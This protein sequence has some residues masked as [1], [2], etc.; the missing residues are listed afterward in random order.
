MTDR[1]APAASR[2]PLRFRADGRFRLMIFS[3]IQEY[4]PFDERVSAFLR[5]AL[6]REQPDLV[7]FGGDNCSGPDIHSREAFISFLDSLLAPVEERG[8][9]WAHLFGNHDHDLFL[10]DD[11]EERL[12]ESHLGCLTG[13]VPG[14]HG[15]TNFVLP[16][17]SRSG[18]KPVFAVWG[19][20]T[21][22]RAAELDSLLPEGC[23]MEPLSYLPRRATPHG[24]WDTLR[25]DQ[26][27]WYW[28]RS[29]ALEAE[30]GHRVPGLMCL[31]IAPEEFQLAADHPD[32]FP[33]S[34]CLSERLGP[35]VLNSG[36][37]SALVQRGDIRCI[38]CGHTHQNDGETELCGIRLCY[39]AS[40]GTRCY[41]D[42]ATRGCRVF[43][44][45]EDE[46]EKPVTR[47]VHR[48]EFGL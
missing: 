9:P 35:A 6:D 4:D 42:E 46:P 36:L 32:I 15:T 33:A 19:L 7:L 22:N 18:E 16:I 48:S 5:A 13:T 31:H 27:M 44:I 12:Y 38:A 45:F 34:G 2:P 47:M 39:S 24:S 37:F 26:L 8:L 10:T 14:I 41:G 21:N 1:N 25:F 17:Y 29:Q 30:A 3:D 23:S 20:D 40:A 28:Q 11:E 43:D